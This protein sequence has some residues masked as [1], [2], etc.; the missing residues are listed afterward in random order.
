MNEFARVVSWGR[1]TRAGEARWNHSHD[2]ASPNVEER[3]AGEMKEIDETYSPEDEATER[4]EKLALQYGVHARLEDAKVLYEAGRI[5][6]ALLT[7][8]VAVAATSKK[9]YPKKTMG[10]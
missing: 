6:G 4:Y 9:R 10:D 1:A 8:L 5:D 7:T 2:R 3:S